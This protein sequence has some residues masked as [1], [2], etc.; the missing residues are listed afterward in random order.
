ML[1]YTTAA[2]LVTLRRQRHRCQHLAPELDKSKGRPA[3]AALFGAPGQTRRPRRPS[4][5][6]WPPARARHTGRSRRRA[7]TTRPPRPPQPQPRPHR[8]L[9]GASLRLCRCCTAANRNK[10]L[11][12]EVSA[13]RTPHGRRRPNAGRTAPQLQAP[14]TLRSVRARGRGGVPEEASSSGRLPAAPPAA[15]AAPA[16]PD[17]ARSA[18]SASAAASSRAAASAAPGAAA[19]SRSAAATSA[20]AASISASAPRSA[21][22]WACAAAAAC[23]LA[24]LHWRGSRFQVLERTPSRAPCRLW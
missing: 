15:A 17:C 7:R 3:S 11:Q 21:A 13:V 16:R 8:R 14:P 1:A 9:H 24:R 6:G 12:N 20:A 19:S 2:L 10:L 22:R 5:A 4:A 23:S 18:P